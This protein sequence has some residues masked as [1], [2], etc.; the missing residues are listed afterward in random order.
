MALILL[1]NWFPFR[2]ARHWNEQAGYQQ[3]SSQNPAMAIVH[4]GGAP[5]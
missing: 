1:S 2:K 5:S 3:E 4:H